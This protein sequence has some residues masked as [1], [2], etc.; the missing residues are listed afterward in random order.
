ML[1]FS[2]KKPYCQSHFHFFREMAAIVANV[3]ALCYDKPKKSLGGKNLESI[4][5]DSAEKYFQS[6]GVIWK[7]VSLRE[8]YGQI[9]RGG[10]IPPYP[11]DIKVRSEVR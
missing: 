1:Y 10:E 3:R 2:E 11:E 4:G 9:S 6:T 7:A 5:N 8:V